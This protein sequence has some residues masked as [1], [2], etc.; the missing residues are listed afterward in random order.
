MW[1]FSRNSLEKCVNL[2]ENT[3]K[4]SPKVRQ[5]PTG[6]TYNVNAKGSGWLCMP[7]Y[8]SKRQVILYGGDVSLW[9]V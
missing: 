2:K 9:S 1:D 5:Y 4:V 6:H 3:P 8:K 7:R